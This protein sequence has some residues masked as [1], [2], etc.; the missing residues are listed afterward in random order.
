MPWPARY[1][2]FLTMSKSDYF[3]RTLEGAP[4]KLGALDGLRTGK[5]LDAEG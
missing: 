3:Q 5:K 2:T 1:V 4:R